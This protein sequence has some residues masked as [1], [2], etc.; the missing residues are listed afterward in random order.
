MELLVNRTPFDGLRRRQDAAVVLE[1]SPRESNHEVRVVR[2]DDEHS[3][4]SATAGHRKPLKRDQ[5]RPGDRHGSFAVGTEVQHL[6]R[7]E[8]RQVLA[9]DPR[10]RRCPR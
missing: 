2:L 6:V 1:V 10:A 5:V 8:E 7:R 3:T 4:L 9:V